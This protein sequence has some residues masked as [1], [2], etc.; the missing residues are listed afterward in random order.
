MDEPKNIK[1]EKN[2]FKIFLWERLKICIYGGDKQNAF[3]HSILNNFEAN[4][5][6]FFTKKRKSLRRKVI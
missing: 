6:P 5:I 4:N 2:E 1:N 3:T